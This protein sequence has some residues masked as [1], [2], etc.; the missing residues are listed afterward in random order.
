MSL[1]PTSRQRR[2]GYSGES[3][4]GTFSSASSALQ[5][6]LATVARRGRCCRWAEAQALRHYATHGGVG[7]SPLLHRRLVVLTGDY[8]TSSLGALSRRSPSPDLSRA[9]DAEALWRGAL[10]AVG[11]IGRVGPS[12]AL[13]VEAPTSSWAGQLALAASQLAITIRVIERPSGPLLIVA[14]ADAAVSVLAITG[15]ARA[16][17]ALPDLVVVPASSPPHCP[18]T[19]PLC[20]NRAEA[21]ARLRR[22]LATLRELGEPIAE[23]FTEVA[24]LRL[25]HPSATLAE[26]AGFADPPLSR[27]VLAGRLRRLHVLAEHRRRYPSTATPRTRATTHETTLTSA[28]KR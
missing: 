6:E 16:A 24:A 20:R 13:V 12:P 14:V 7:S 25:A 3:A 28:S 23:P 9:C 2:P 18:V 15:A 27:H 1:I 5:A 4:P 26:L 21:L 22:D 11:R 19:E 10:V 8:D 17:R